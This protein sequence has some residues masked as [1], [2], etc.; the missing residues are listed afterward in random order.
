MYE[1][2]RGSR[3]KGSVWHFTIFPSYI[4]DRCGNVVWLNIARFTT[5]HQWISV[6]S[7][8]D[9]NLY[10]IKSKIFFFY[11]HYLRNYVTKI[12]WIILDGLFCSLTLL[13]GGMRISH[14]QSISLSG[15][16]WW[17]LKNS[18]G[19]LRSF[20]SKLSSPSITVWHSEIKYY[21]HVCT[22]KNKNLMSPSSVSGQ[23][24]SIND[25]RAA[26]LACIGNPLINTINRGPITTNAKRTSI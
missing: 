10:K 8:T 24:H 19:K 17:K 26:A 5:R 3:D 16:F 22:L 18:A 20:I 11:V 9:K 14:T 21:W 2:T 15:W 6:V 25:S 12:S 23:W 1:S 4:R 13:I 7:Y